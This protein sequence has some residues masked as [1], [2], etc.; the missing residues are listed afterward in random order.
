DLRPKIF[1]LEEIED[2][3]VNAAGDTMTGPL[4]MEADI[5]VA[6]GQRV[7]GVCVIDGDALCPEVVQ[8]R[9]FDRTEHLLGDAGEVPTFSEV[10]DPL[11]PKYFPVH[12][13]RYYTKTE[14][15]NLIGTNTVNNGLF[16]DGFE[17]W[18]NAIPQPLFGGPAAE[19][20]QTTTVSLGL[21][22]SL[23]GTDCACRTLNVCALPGSRVCFVCPIRQEVSLRCGGKFVL[24]QKLCVSKGDE[25]VRPYFLL[26]MFSSCQFVGTKRV[27]M[28][29][30]PSDRPDKCGVERADGITVL[31]QQVILP[32]C[33][34]QVFL[35]LCYDV[36]TQ[37]ALTAAE[38]FPSSPLPPSPLPSPAPPSPTPSP[39]S[40]EAKCEVGPEGLEWNVCSVQMRRVTG[41]E[42]EDPSLGGNTTAEPVI[43]SCDVSG[44]QRRVCYAPGRGQVS[45]IL[46]RLEEKT[47]GVFTGKFPTNFPGIV[48]DPAADTCV[49]EVDVLTQAVSACQCLLTCTDPGA[50]KAV[51]T[52]FLYGAIN[53]NLGFGCPEITDEALGVSAGTAVDKLLVRVDLE[54]APVDFLQLAGA[55]EDNT[56]VKFTVGRT[57]PP[58]SVGP[59]LNFRV[60]CVDDEGRRAMYGF[61]SEADAVYK[62]VTIPLSDFQRLDASAFDWTQVAAVYVGYAIGLIG[63][64]CMFGIDNLRFCT[65]TDASTY[66]FGQAASVAPHDSEEADEDCV[67]LEDFGDTEAK[68]APLDRI[69]CNAAFPL[70]VTP[71]DADADFCELVGAIA[72]EGEGTGAVS[73]TVSTGIQPSAVSV[74]REF[75][76]TPLDLAT[77]AVSPS[78]FSFA[79][80]VNRAGMTLWAV[81]YS[82]NGGAAL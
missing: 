30:P 14:I 38:V 80:D 61:E 53:G 9:H 48:L 60:I 68:G 12:D 23:C 6:P 28:F 55:D 73:F 35:T 71:P 40:L 47:A 21:C 81:A 34:D 45:L 56:A 29:E 16:D 63:E 2:R 1:T 70:G 25:C 22:S 33:V 32:Q 78:R 54:G 62:T 57:P 44:G 74:G 66:S 65:K 3:F 8:Q 24:I 7:T 51:P 49:D 67:T 75:T 50:P 64:S 11:D 36:T 42:A 52:C 17:G 5:E 43:E 79:V 77:D 27:D 76:A 18:E 19:A 4:V 58:S 69:T 37:T 31:E 10:N 26:D 20:A 72:V 41:I 82:G 46:E 13:N 15:D 59:D 39:G